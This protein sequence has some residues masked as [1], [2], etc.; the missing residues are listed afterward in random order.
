[1]IAS[2]PVV[3]PA[4]DFAEDAARMERV[5]AAIRAIRA[6]RNEMNVPPSR[7]AKI[8]IATKYAE[9]FEGSEA[10]FKRLASASEIARITPGDG[11]KGDSLVLSLIYFLSVGCSPGV[12]AARAWYCSA[13]KRLM[14]L[15]FL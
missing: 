14:V 13:R 4:L 2:Y 6:R 3:D 8:F 5:I 10:F 12:Y 1:M 15:P 11:G 9:S 7:K